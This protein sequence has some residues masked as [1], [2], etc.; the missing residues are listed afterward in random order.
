MTEYGGR[1]ASRHSY[2]GSG[3][4]DMRATKLILSC[5]FCAGVLLPMAAPRPALSAEPVKIRIGWLLVPAEITPIL[6]PEPGI[7]KHAGKSY[8]LEPIRF[9]GSPLL[10]TALASGEIDV[11][12]FG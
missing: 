7:A 6:F 1:K 11:A 10:T 5:L 4:N 3:G 12:P 2:L 8:V 9:Q